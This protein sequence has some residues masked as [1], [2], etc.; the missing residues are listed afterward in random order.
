LRGSLVS[1][2]LLVALA[3]LVELGTRLA[4]DRVFTSDY[5]LADDDLGF[6]N[7]PT[8]RDLWDA[9][10]KYEFRSNSLGFRGPELP[11]GPAPA[12]TERVLLVG[13]SFVHGWG[14]REE[15]WMGTA[16]REGLAAAGRPAEVYSL[17][18]QDWGTA[19]EL[20]ALRRYGDR[21]RPDTVVLVVYH[22]NDLLNNE[23]TLAGRS[24][25]SA[26]D[27]FRP[28]LVPDGDGGLTRRY[29]LPWRGRMRRSV[30]FRVLERRANAGRSA[31]EMRI[32]IAGD[33]YTDYEER[34][35]NGDLPER[36]FE[37]FREPRPGDPWSAAWSTTEALFVAMRAEAARLGADFQIAVIPNLLQVV[38]TS[39]S[40][41]H[42]TRLAS[43]GREPLVS[44]LDLDLPERRMEE[45]FH[46]TGIAHVQ[47]LDAYRA[48]AREGR[49]TVFVSDGHI[50]GAAQ[51]ALG[52]AIAARMAP[53]A[54]DLCARGGEP[55]VD[56][57]S[58][59]GEPPFELDLEREEHWPFLGFGWARWLPPDAPA[60]HHGWILEGGGNFAVRSGFYTLEGTLTKE[61][62]FPV[63][64]AIAHIG[65]RG[66]SLAR[67]E[68]A[69]PGPF[70]IEVDTR[71][72][73]YAPDD[74]WL[75]LRL[76]AEGT[77]RPARGGAPSL[78]LQT[79]RVAVAPPPGWQ[80]P[81]AGRA[82]PSV[83]RRTWIRVVA[84]LVRIPPRLIQYVSWRAPMA[85]F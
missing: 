59:Q 22:A 75:V 53:G 25:I 49:A 71:G 65:P 43:L 34:L 50:D 40:K 78:V 45:L 6:R 81:P 66:A 41:A 47:M 58:M 76:N 55:P 7:P 42:D 46:R 23:I 5:L 63:K 57:L 69:A 12:G 74:P 67:Q 19:Q 8:A 4:V 14:V 83:P 11:T 10:G 72:L 54:A 15:E 32:Q 84:A 48:L 68:L 33:P 35:R 17:C 24:T 85:A 62:R 52:R 20:L 1:V 9:R 18:T 61:C 3:G 30:L 60:Q 82:H 37:I 21:V 36:H 80:P 39:F 56:L 51:T 28:Y 44:M 26:G 77:L 73:P 16:V 13:D 27:Y 31:E 70:A 38:Q 79:I 64:L 29:A 2:V